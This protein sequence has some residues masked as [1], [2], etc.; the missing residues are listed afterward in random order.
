MRQRVDKTP[1]DPEGAYLA[2]VTRLEKLFEEGFVRGIC[3]LIAVSRSGLRESD[4]EGAFQELGMDFNPADFS[5]LRHLL[6][7][8]ISQGD[9]QQWNFSH[10]S[11]RKALKKDRTDELQRLNESLIAHFHRTIEQDHF[12]AREMMHHLATANKPD[13]AAEILSINYDTHS[14]ALAQGLADVYVE[15]TNGSEFLSAIP[16]HPEHIDGPKRRYVLLAIRDCLPLLPENTRPFRAELMLTSLSMLDTG[17]RKVR[18]GIWGSIVGLMAKLLSMFNGQEDIETQWARAL[19]ESTLADVYTEIGE[20]EKAGEYY[21]KCLEALD[22]IYL[23]TGMMEALRNVSVLWGKMGDHFT[24]WGR[25]EEAGEYYQK[26]LEALDQIYQKTGTTEALRDVA[27]SWT[28]MGNHFAKRG[29]VQE[30]G[31]YYHKSLEA[32]EAIYQQTEAME[33]LRELSVSWSRMGCA[34]HG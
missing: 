6:P 5:W 28:N 13:V 18:K 21:Q 33:A 23:K 14:G 15:H 3:G 29:R 9:M 27:V 32:S 12:V 8:H 34:R 24:K 26:C 19:G 16:A 1:G 20:S 11:L 22:Q 17:G 10:Q 7:G 4:M 2:I 31:E 30:A 25:V